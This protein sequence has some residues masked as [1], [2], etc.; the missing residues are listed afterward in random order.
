VLAVCGLAEDRIRPR[1]LLSMPGLGVLM[2]SPKRVRPW[3]PLLVT[4]SALRWDEVLSVLSRGELVRC[5]GGVCDG[6]SSSVIVWEERQCYD[7]LKT[8]SM[9]MACTARCST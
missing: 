3:P 5:C 6:E 9:A 4:G 7:A 8:R 1:S 2:A